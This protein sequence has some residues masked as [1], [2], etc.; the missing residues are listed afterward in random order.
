VVGGFRPVRR[1]GP[2]VASPRFR[3]RRIGRST[4]AERG[5]RSPIHL[6]PDR[7]QAK[8]SGMTS[9]APPP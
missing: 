8:T 3:I 7:L 4:A 9:Y 1:Y 6:I 2:S 5:F